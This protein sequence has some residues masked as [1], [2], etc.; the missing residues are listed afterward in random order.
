MRKIL[1][2][3]LLAL[4]M[5]ACGSTRNLD[6]SKLRTG[7]TKAQVQSMIGNPDRILAVNET[8]NGHQE[9]LEYRTSRDEVY[10]L[11]FWNDYLTGYEF[12]YDDPDYYV[13]YYFPPTY[14]TVFPEYGR[15]IYIIQEN[16]PNRPNRP[17]PPNR[18]NRPNRPS[19]PEINRPNMTRP[20]PNVRPTTRPTTRP[21]V[22]SRPQHSIDRSG[23][24]R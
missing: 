19:R 20:T 10:G 13:N 11:E 5:T 7:M 8:E 4:L 22:E 14:P 3:S 23:L 24:T 12:L 17:I 1:L 15:P 9:I 2:L 16:R 21:S 18:P 6:L